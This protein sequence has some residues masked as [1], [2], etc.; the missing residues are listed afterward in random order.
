MS[1]QDI[2]GI[3][4]KIIDDTVFQRSFLVDQDAFRNQPLPSHHFART[5]QTKKCETCTFRKVCELLIQ[6][7]EK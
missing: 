5:S 4:Q 6:Q 7:E 2:D 1:Q 3:L